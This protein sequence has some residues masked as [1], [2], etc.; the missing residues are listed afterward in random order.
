MKRPTFFEGV[1]VA[2][3]ASLAG[4]VLY[5]ALGT[6]LPSGLVLRLVVAGLGLAYVL[7]LLGRTSER[8]GR[9]TT[10]V[11]WLVAAGLVWMFVPTL[12]LYVLLHLGL[13]WLIRSLYFH[14]SL[15][16]A[17]ADLGQSGLALAAGVWALLHTGSLFLALWCFFLVQAL[18][19]AI[20]ASPRRGHTAVKPDADDHFQQA[21]RV[22]EAAV[23]RLSTIR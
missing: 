4:S 14:A 10:L 21:H 7:Y 5:G 12:T 20:P 9:I 13:V 19:V 6:V 11:A 16:A 23:R 3:V 1:G 8:V 22:A 18:F 17:L 15:L 2:L